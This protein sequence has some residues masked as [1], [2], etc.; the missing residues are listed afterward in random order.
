MGEFFFVD[1]YDD[2]LIFFSF[3]YFYPSLPSLPIS[4]FFCHHHKGKICQAHSQWTQATSWWITDLMSVIL[5]YGLIT[6]VLGLH[7]N[8][9]HVI[10]DFFLQYCNCDYL[11]QLIEFAFIL[12]YWFIVCVGGGGMGMHRGRCFK[13]LNWLKWISPNRF[14]CCMHASC[15]PP[16]TFTKMEAKMLLWLS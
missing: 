2:L 11:C 16:Q 9:K 5:L 10:V 12:I 4:F 15:S 3:N 6:S 8:E 13:S 1:F 7:D 14:N